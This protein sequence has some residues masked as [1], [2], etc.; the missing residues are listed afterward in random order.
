LKNLKAA[1][2]LDICE[3]VGCQE[4]ATEQITVSAGELGTLIL[5]VCSNCISKFIDK[6]E[7]VDS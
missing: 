1:D 2:I 4:Q 3:A 6:V 7:V 5:S